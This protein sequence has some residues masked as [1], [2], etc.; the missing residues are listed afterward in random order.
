[1]TDEKENKH[2]HLWPS[3]PNI[4][5][6]IDELLSGASPGDVFVF[7]YAGHCDLHDGNHAY[8]VTRDEGKIFGNVSITHSSVTRC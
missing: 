8:I 1:M 2:T 3:R 6:A 7:Y 4:L 5:N